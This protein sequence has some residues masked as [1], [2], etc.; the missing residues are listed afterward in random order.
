MVTRTTVR[1]T[2]SFAKAAAETPRTTASIDRAHALQ[3]LAGRRRALVR[4]AR[5]HIVARFACDRHAEKLIAARPIL[6]R[7]R[8]ALERRRDRARRALQ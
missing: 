5:P 7:D 3:K 1:N 2:A 8:D 4:R 6:P